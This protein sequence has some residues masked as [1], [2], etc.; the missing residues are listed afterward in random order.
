MRWQ[1]SD[2]FRQGPLPDYVTTLDVT[3]A[4]CDPAH[5]GVWRISN[6]TGALSQPLARGDSRAVVTA[7]SPPTNGDDLVIEAGT[8]QVEVRNI[9]E[10]SGSGPWIVVL[11]AGLSKDHP[12]GAAAALAYTSDGTHPSASLHKAAAAILEAYK[13]KGVLP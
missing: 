13:A 12:A 8:P 2:W 10:V 1:A 4:F 3:P 6:W 5:P 9:V 7:Q 11:T